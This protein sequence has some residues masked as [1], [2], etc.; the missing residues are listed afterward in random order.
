MLFRGRR[1]DRSKKWTDELACIIPQAA[2]SDKRVF[3]IEEKD[4]YQIDIVE[5]GVSL[6]VTL[7]CSCELPVKKVEPDSFYCQHCDRN[8]NYQNCGFCK[9]L[10][11]VF[12][13]RFPLK[14]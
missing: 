2:Q 13:L 7:V 9:S 1:H 11:E 12:E 3:R 6:S 5:E 8:C 14:G 4:L 10:D